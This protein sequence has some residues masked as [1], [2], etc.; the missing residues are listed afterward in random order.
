MH[1]KI[2]EFSKKEFTSSFLNKLGQS[3]LIMIGTKLLR[4]L[5]DFSKRI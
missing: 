2:I 1:E 3:G 5:L 4:Y